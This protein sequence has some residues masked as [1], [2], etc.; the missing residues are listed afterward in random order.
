MALARIP[1]NRLVQI[2]RAL[3]ADP[4]YFLGRGIREEQMDDY[5][6]AAEALFL[7]PAIEAIPSL[8]APQQKLIQDLIL[9]MKRGG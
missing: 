1:L 8:T 9:T 3:K 6:A 4:A 7:V 5:P 2:S